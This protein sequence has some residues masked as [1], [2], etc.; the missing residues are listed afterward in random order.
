MRN[1]VYNPFGKSLNE[2][3][4]SDLGILKD[5][6]EGWYVEYKGE[7]ITNRNIAK[8]ISAFANHF[9]GWL[10]FGIVSDA[11]ARTAQSFPGIPASEVATLEERIK[12]AVK[13][14]IHPG[15]FYNHVILRGPNSNIG[16]AEDRVVVAVAIPSGVNPPYIMDGKI[17]R[18]IA[19]SSAPKPETD[20]AT[21]DIL[22]ERGL[23]ARKRLEEFISEAPALSKA[24]ENLC[25]LHF[26]ITSDPYLEAGLNYNY[27]FSRFAEIMSKQPI[28]FDNMYT[29]SNGFIA[30]QAKHNIPSN[31][32]LT[33]EFYNH[34]STIFHIPFNHV[35]ISE[36]YENDWLEGYENAADFVN[37][38]KKFGL[39]SGR[40]LDLNWV[41][42]LLGAAIHRHRILI[43]DLGIKGP[44]YLKANLQNI[45]RCIPFIDLKGFTDLITMH[46]VPVVQD[47][48]TFAP[49]GATFESFLIIPERAVPQLELSLPEYAEALGDAIP[50]FLEILSA[51]GV[52]ASILEHAPM[53]LLKVNSR[54]EQVQVIRNKWK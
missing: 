26:I 3:S 25:S 41:F 1:L 8:A 48:D 12:N 31:F 22:F 42:H 38:C 6:A 30:R 10:F 7:L 15:P 34:C 44:F 21:I 43:G 18:R 28:S 13:D 51:L 4:T 45:W 11:S 32:I 40:V 20:R 2:L 54:A 17:Y 29:K 23:K 47:S 46:G 9:G 39:R 50:L 27:G 53:D 14:L 35:D 49:Y 19:D 5:I 33:W 36:V 24:E 52:P 16:L 37:I